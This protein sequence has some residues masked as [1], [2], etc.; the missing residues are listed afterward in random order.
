MHYKNGREA[1][2][3]DQVIL[4]AGVWPTHVG[5]L[6]NAQAGNDYCNGRIAPIRKRSCPQPERLLH[7]DDF[8]AAF[9]SEV[10]D[11]SK[12][13]PKGEPKAS[14]KG[15]P[16]AIP[17]QTPAERQT[18]KHR[19]KWST[20][21]RGSQI[22]ERIAGAL[23][24]LTVAGS[25]AFF[26]WDAHLTQAAARGAIAPSSGTLTSLQETLEFIKRPCASVDAKGKLLQ[27]GP[28]CELDQAIHDIRKIVTLAR[29]QVKQT[30]TVV[31]AAADS[32]DQV[33]R[34][35]C[36]HKRTRRRKPWTQPGNV[37]PGDRDAET[38]R[39]RTVRDH[40]V[41]GELRCD[42]DQRQRLSPAQGDQRLC[43]QPRSSQRERCSD[44]RD[45]RAYALDRGPGRDQGSVHISA[46]ESG[47]PGSAPGT[48]R[49][50]GC[51]SARKDLLDSL[52]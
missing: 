4:L 19:S 16:K 26:A 42:R 38:G 34:R 45:R 1:K 37:R 49:S 18:K 24:F 14:T 15:K 29:N 20:R 33:G 52:Q 6:Y 12:P 43:E 17:R 44:Q 9:L 39:Q 32:L 8:T 50:P 46:S 22:I 41:D 35:S 31:R 5:I 23:C 36:R 47:V 2:N 40:A 27:D 25:A 48:P 3:G 30:D 11:T 51:R 28:I 13:Q 21:D 7:V 10:P